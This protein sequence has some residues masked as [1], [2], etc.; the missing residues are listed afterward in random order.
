MLQGRLFSYWDAQ[1]YRLRVNFHQIPVN[2]PKC[3]VHNYHRDG[4]MR[5]DDTEAARSRT[6][7]TG[8]ASG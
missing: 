7:R 5:V 8:E 4:A 3:P 1:R 6:R 2:A